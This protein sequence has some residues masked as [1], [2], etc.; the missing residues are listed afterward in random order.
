[1][2]RPRAHRRAHPPPTVSV[3]PLPEHGD[4]AVEIATRCPHAGYRTGWQLGS[5]VT[6]HAATTASI[7][8]HAIMEACTCMDS[9]WR[10]HRAP[11]APEDLAGLVARFNRLWEGIEGQQRQR[12]FAVVNWDEAV[13]EL[14]GKG[15]K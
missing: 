15:A 4:G 8:H 13:R 10:R 14:A 7:A 3:R 5:T 11:Q 6:E 2:T 1:M 9:L 12:G